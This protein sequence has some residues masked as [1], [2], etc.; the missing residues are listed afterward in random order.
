[1]DNN[2]IIEANSISKRFDLGKRESHNSL[3]DLISDIPS[4][5]HKKKPSRSNKNFWALRDISFKLRKGDTLGIIGPNGAGKST[6]LKI[7]A[8]IIP[9]TSG[10][11]TIN[12]RMATMLE[13]GT[14]FHSELTGRENIYLNGAI[15]GMK[16]SEIDR[17]FD[18]IV[19]FSGVRQFLDMPVK[20]YS[21]GMQVRLAF[22]VA[23]HL[24][25]EIL[26]IDEVLSVGDMSFQRKSLAKMYSIAKDEGR[27]IV[28]VSHNMA[29]IDAICNKALLL[30]K[31]QAVYGD[32]QEIIAKYISDFSPKGESFVRTGNRAGNGKIR[33]TGFWMEN[34]EGKKIE[35]ARTGSRC[36]FVFSFKCKGGRPQKDV[37]FGFNVYTATEQALFLVYRSYQNKDLARCPAQGRFVFAFNKFPLAAG[38]YK[39]GIRATVKEEEA[40]YLP[41]AA[42]F[43]VNDG[44]FY[45][46]KIP[47]SQRHS[48][49]YVEGRWLDIS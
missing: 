25:P 23:A 9:P 15:L 14:G 17:K 18:K 13:V 20:K 28:M 45:E 24:D 49:M 3:R 38:R 47:T 8:R 32:T 35:A 41:T 5:I 11:A 39:L 4:V 44:N 26:L 48:P 2:I 33:I 12:G 34:E 6:L 36:N 29:A 21:S 19:S 7:L 46:T 43:N 37:D 30:E 22:S 42:F 31:G 27:T 10:M 16:H 1:M 40:D